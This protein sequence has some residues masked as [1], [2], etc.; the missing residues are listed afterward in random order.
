[1]QNQNFWND[2]YSPSEYSEKH[3]MTSVGRNS[4]EFCN[5]YSINPE[6]HPIGPYDDFFMYSNDIPSNSI[7]SME[8]ATQL[9]TIPSNN[10]KTSGVPNNDLFVD[11]S[12]FPESLISP[13]SAKNSDEKHINGQNGRLLSDSDM[14][15]SV[16]QSRDHL[17]PSLSTLSKL[18]KRRNSLPSNY[19]SD[20]HPSIDSEIQPIYS[21]DIFEI[22]SPCSSSDVVK[23]NSSDNVSWTNCYVPDRKRATSVVSSERGLDSLVNKLFTDEQKKRYLASKKKQMENKKEENKQMDLD[24]AY[25]SFL[26]G[27][28]SSQN[29]SVFDNR[30]ITSDTDEIVVDD[31]MFLCENSTDDCII[32]TTSNEIDMNSKNPEQVIFISNPVPEETSI[33][34]SSP[35]LTIN[36]DSN[37]QEVEHMDCETIDERT[38]SG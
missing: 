33:D 2:S 19:A 5:S 14:H 10:V 9:S 34:I 29:S 3:W 12:T 6:S 1:M 20:K 31:K 22:N 36:T 35:C 38:V 25:K 4:D 27:M 18:T 8:L 26:E 11:S 21:T 15:F 30:D 37:Q 32:N 24:A 28:T 13:S 7:N 16:S 23:G 17:N